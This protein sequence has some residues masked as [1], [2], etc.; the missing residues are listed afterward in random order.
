MDISSFE[1][2]LCIGNK[3]D[4]VQSTEFHEEASLIAEGTRDSKESDIE[5]LRR[6][7]FGWCVDNGMEFIESCAVDP[8]FDKSTTSRFIVGIL[9]A[10]KSFFPCFPFVRFIKRGG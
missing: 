6:R 1:T 9:R 3:A 5:N 8:T 10:I 4:K 7:V 2:R